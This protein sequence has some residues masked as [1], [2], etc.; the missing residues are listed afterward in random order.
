MAKRD[1][2]QSQKGGTNKKSGEAFLAKKKT[3]KGVKSTPSGLLY[4]VIVGGKGEKPKATDTVQVHYRGTMIDGTEFD[5]S[6]GRGVPATFPVNGVIRGWTE[7]LQLMKVGSKWEL[8]IPSELAY[9]E[10]GAGE[11]I[12]P[13]STLIFTVELLGIQ[14][15]E[16][17]VPPA[18]KAQ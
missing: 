4:K 2:E 17:S 6:Y 15:P 12:G 5:S 1:A 14:K 8:Y 10:R 7:A 18:P 9:G 11:Q 3:E 16:P 13:N